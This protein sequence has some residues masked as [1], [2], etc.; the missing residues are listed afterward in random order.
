[1]FSG[2]SP[3]VIED[4]VD[5]GERILVLAWTPQGTADCPVCEAPSVRVHGYHLRTVADTPVDGR[6]VV[7]RVKVRRLVCPTRGC[8]HTFREQVPGVLERYQ[9]RTARLTSQVKAVVKELAGRA[10]SR[11]LSTWAVCVSRH[12]ALRALLRIPLPRPRVPRVIG[13]DDFALRR[14]HRY[15]TVV[16]DAETH[17]RID[18]LPDRKAETLEAWLHDHPG[19]EIVCRDGSA[20]YA[21]AIRRGAPD[22]VQVSDRWHLWHGLARAAEKAVAAHSTCWAKAGP[23]RQELTRERT[24]LERWHAIHDLIDNG[25]GLLDCA[26]RLNLALN[27]VKRYARAPEPDRLRRPPQ[28]RVCLV[29]PYRDHLRRRRTEEPG[30]PVKH[31][32]E[33]IRAL[34]YSGSLNLLHKYLN[35]G[36]LEGDRIMPSPRRLTSWIMTRPE[37]LPDKHRAHLDELLAACPEM[38][39]LARLVRA[40]AQLMAERRGSDLGSW[41]ADVRS[42][43]L[44]ELVPFLNGLD[45]DR[46]AVLAGLT[47]PYRNGPTEGVNTKT[48]L[49]A[50]QMYG[51]AGFPLLRHRILLG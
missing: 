4:V 21:G 27:T 19:V 12:T 8:C 29:D 25:V 35:Q 44:P 49:I 42:A 31:L 43:Q 45:Q 40:F 30:V 37:N 34:G 6:R 15:A 39:A 2:L 28:Y 22:A 3:L 36:R 11:L 13:V 20:S 26:R 41:M 5:E 23:K 17:D 50:R 51:R 38:M 14:R 1:M 47:L 46:E 10:G 48:K 9:R 24:T 16:I 7:V 33:E 32:F 18:V